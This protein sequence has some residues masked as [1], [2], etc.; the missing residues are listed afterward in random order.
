MVLVLLL[1]LVLGVGSLQLILEWYIPFSC[2]LDLSLS[3]VNLHDDHML[4]ET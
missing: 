3:Q 1:E 4:L 2:E